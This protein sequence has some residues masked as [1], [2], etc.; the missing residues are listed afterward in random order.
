MENPCIQ[1][2]L[3]AGLLKFDICQTLGSSPIAKVKCGYE[4]QD[5]KKALA[6]KLLCDNFEDGFNIYDMCKNEIKLMA[7]LNHQNVVRQLGYGEAI[8]KN[9][10]G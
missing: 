4:D 1:K 6:I 2:R 10:R 8:Y 7:S 5:P 9:H 3:D